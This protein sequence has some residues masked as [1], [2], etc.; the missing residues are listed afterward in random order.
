MFFVSL[1]PHELCE[2]IWNHLTNCWAKHWFKFCSSPLSHCLDMVC[3]Y[4]SIRTDKVI[5]VV[6]N[7]VLETLRSNAI[8]STPHIVPNFSSW[9]DPL[10][11]E[12]HQNSS[13]PTWNSQQK[14]FFGC[15][16][17]TSKN[18]LLWY[19]AHSVVSSSRKKALVWCLLFISEIGNDYV[20][21][22]LGPVSYGRFATDL[23][24]ILGVFQSHSPW[25]SSA[26][27]PKVQ[28]RFF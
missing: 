4:V 9:P 11:D 8:L 17:I 5:L 28:V 26:F 15:R 20:P 12:M 3:C 18:Q 16:I 22:I 13:T 23:Q 7:I 2:V 14:A 1:V 19:D 10:Y 24:F 27:A 21:T 6:N 25:L